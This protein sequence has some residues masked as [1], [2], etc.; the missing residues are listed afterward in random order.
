MT[1]LPP[2]GPGQGRRWRRLADARRRARTDF[3]LAVLGA[4]PA[5]PC[6]APAAAGSRDLRAA[7]VRGY[8][9]RCPRCGLGELFDRRG[10]V[11]AACA[12]CGQHLLDND[13]AY[14]AELMPAFAV[15]SVVSVPVGCVLLWIAV[16]TDWPAWAIIAG[17]LPVVWILAIAPIQPVRGMAISLQWANRLNSFAREAPRQS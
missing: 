15:Q 1:S 10:R 16:I 17:A 7:M 5:E 6:G 4:A 8:L 9:G 13:A 14:D 11:T 12:C 2:S 3:W